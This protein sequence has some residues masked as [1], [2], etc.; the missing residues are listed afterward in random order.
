MKTCRVNIEKQNKFIFNASRNRNT[1]GIEKNVS[2]TQ[3]TKYTSLTCII[4]LVGWSHLD[5]SKVRVIKSNSSLCFS[6]VK[7]MHVIHSFPNK[8]N[9]KFC[10]SL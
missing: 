4:H 3:P 1:F 7:T 8:S 2:Q 10:S 5:N 9:A 6:D